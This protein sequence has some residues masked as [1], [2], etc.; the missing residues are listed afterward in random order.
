M[1]CMQRLSVCKSAHDRKYDRK[2]DTM[3]GHISE[4]EYIQT[5]FEES[6]AVKQQII[7]SH[8]DVIVHMATIISDSL[9]QGNKMLLCGNGGS[10]ADAQHLAAE[11]LIRL[12]ATVNRNGIPALTLATDTSSM[13]ACSND[14]SFESYFARMVQTLGKPGDVLLGIST[15]GTSPNIVR[16]LE[17]AQSM[18]IQT[19]G[20]L[21]GDGGQA[22][23]VCDIALV[24]PSCVTGRI[25][26][27]HITAGHAL[28]ELIENKL[29]AR[30]FLIQ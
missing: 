6:I 26:E 24:V 7:A 11:L 29:L 23:E 15:S 30:G 17:Q 19:L 4:H 25:Q 28:I 14:Y 1:R 10:A 16:A 13:T 8:L 21:G 5:L 20:F 22:R 12:R 18:G 3:S 27:S 9:E 2:S